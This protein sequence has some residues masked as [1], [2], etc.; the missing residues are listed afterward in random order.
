MTT[1]ISGNT[2]STIGNDTTISGDI[3]ADNLPANGSIVGYQQGVWAPVFDSTTVSGGALAGTPY[4]EVSWRRI[5][6]LVSLNYSF[7]LGSGVPGN[8]NVND[9]WAFTGLPYNASSFGQCLSQAWTTGSW[10]SG[11]RWFMN[12]FITNSTG[13]IKW[14]GSFAGNTAT[15]RAN[16]IWRCSLQYTTDDTTWTPQ[17][18]ATVS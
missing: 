2:P 10:D 9:T 13:L 4:S 6:D 18:G 15:V 7:T 12:A 5:G 1:I 11:N 3:T 16:K 8:L 14:G 17:N